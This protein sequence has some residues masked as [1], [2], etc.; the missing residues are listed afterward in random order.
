VGS[1]P[2]INPFHDHDSDDYEADDFDADAD[3]DGDDYEADDYDDAADAA[4]DA[5]YDEEHRDRTR[6][7]TRRAAPSGGAERRV[8]AQGRSGRIAVDADADSQADT[9]HASDPDTA[10]T[11]D[12][13]GTVVE[14]GRPGGAAGLSPLSSY[15]VATHGP[16]PAP[17]WLVTALSARDTPWG[18]LKS[19]KEADVSLLERAVPG[20]A[21][22]LLAVKTYRTAEHRM[23]HRDAGYLEGRRVRRSRETRAM[24][25]RTTFGRDLLAGQWAVAEFGA[26]SALWASGARVPYPVQLIGSELMM[27]FIGEPDGTA[28]P[29]LA[30]YDGS[31]AEFVDLWHDLV[32]TLEVLAADGMTHGDLSA[33]NVLVDDDGCMLIDLPQVVDLIGNPQGRAFLERDCRRIA[34]FFARRGV[35]TADGGA[36]SEHLWQIAT[37]IG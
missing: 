8:V 14:I 31:S 30:T 35:A 7:R 2:D 27:Q 1:Q 11:P 19:G 6:R 13:G 3:H 25:K 10:R 4:L 21:S 28:A 16:E 18:A 5:L 24:A 23:F 36:L 12:T 20:G 37:P 15:D 22:C 32:A 9:D 17:G 33:Y 26:L 34:D 29:R